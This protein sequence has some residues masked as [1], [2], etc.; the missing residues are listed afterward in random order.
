MA[1]KSKFTDITE[2]AFGQL[3]LD[4]GG[5]LSFLDLD[6]GDMRTAELSRQI[7]LHS[8]RNKRN[9]EEEGVIVSESDSSEIEMWNRDIG[10]VLGKSGR[11][12]I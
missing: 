6:E 7:F 10:S 9:N 4:F 12:M 3:L 11:E 5:Q 8:E 2:E 1:L